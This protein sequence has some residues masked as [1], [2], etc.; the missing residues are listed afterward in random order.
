MTITTPKA[1]FTYETITLQD[2]LRTSAREVG[3]KPALIH[4]DTSLSFSDLDAR[5]DRLAG[6]LGRRGIGTGDRVTIFM[7]NS[8]AFVVAFYGVLRAGAVVNPISALSK[9]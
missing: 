1:A 8:I 6:A 4:G 3:A 2:R 7:P 9:E 5:A